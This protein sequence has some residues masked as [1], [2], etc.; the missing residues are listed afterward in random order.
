M[1]HHSGSVGRGWQHSG[2]CGQNG[3]EHCGRIDS[4][5]CESKIVN[6]IEHGVFQFRWTI[7]NVKINIL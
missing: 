7:K 1:L 4:R 2:V 5:H 6:T 3:S